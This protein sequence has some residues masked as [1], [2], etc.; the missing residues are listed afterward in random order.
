MKPENAP[1]LTEW[2]NATEVAAMLGISRQTANQMIHA[3][4]FKTLHLS[5]LEGQ[6]PSYMIKRKEVEKMVES[7]DFPRS[8]KK[9]PEP[10]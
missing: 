9:D 10:A 3:G 7:R 8:P 6:K 2:M 5:G 1:R 4:E